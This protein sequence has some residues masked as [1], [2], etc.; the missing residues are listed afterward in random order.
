M[1]DPETKWQQTRG[2]VIALVAGVVMWPILG[3]W[4]ALSWVGQAFRDLLEDETH[5]DKMKGG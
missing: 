5:L 2:V 1:K 4:K 3:L